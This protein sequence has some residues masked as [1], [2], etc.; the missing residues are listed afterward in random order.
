MNPAGRPYRFAVLLCASLM[1][2]GSYFAYDSVGAIETTLIKVFQLYFAE[3]RYKKA[4][5]SLDRAVEVDPYE[6]GHST[7]LEM[8]RGKIDPLLL[9]TIANRLPNAP[10]TEAVPANEG[11]VQESEPTVLE[12]FILQAEIYLQY[13]M[14]TKAIDRLVRVSR[15]F[16][17]EEE[18]NEK[19]RE[20]AEKVLKE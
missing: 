12:D 2:F 14:R 13:G 20:R 6:P 3:G 7:R 9:N 18:K 11:G 19:L 17:H 8:L 4:G 15:L 16:P 5:E 10:P 1:A